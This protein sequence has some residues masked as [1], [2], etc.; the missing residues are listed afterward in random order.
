MCCRPT[1]RRYKTIITCIWISRLIKRTIWSG[2]FPDWSPGPRNTRFVGPE[3]VK[4]RRILVR[5]VAPVAKPVGIFRHVVLQVDALLTNRAQLTTFR[6][7]HDKESDDTNAQKP[8][9]ETCGGKG[10]VE[11]YGRHH[12]GQPHRDR[13]SHKYTDV[14]GF[15][16]NRG[17]WSK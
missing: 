11:D 3:M 12:P 15:P 14:L 8:E 1:C 7:K 2:F 9:T 17:N 13:H 6:H 5:V 10:I 16:K 4:W